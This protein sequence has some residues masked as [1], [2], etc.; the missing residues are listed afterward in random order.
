MRK[1]LTLVAMLTSAAT[2]ASAWYV[3]TH[4]DPM[5]DRIETSALVIDGN[6]TLYVGCMNGQPQARLMWPKR[7]GYGDSVGLSFRIDQGEVVPRFAFLSQD[8]KDLWPWPGA[9]EEG[10]N[11][12][13]RG[14]RLRVSISGNVFNFDLGQGG[15]PLPTI[16]CAPLQ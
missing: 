13:A 8:G 6:A 4:K 3:S 14:K 16:K 15:S 2:P 7:V 10:I 11:A 9:P 1:I 12:L 5:T